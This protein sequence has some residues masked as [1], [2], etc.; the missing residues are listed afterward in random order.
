MTI[1]SGLRHIWPRILGKLWVVW[2]VRRWGGQGSLWPGAPAMQSPFAGRSWTIGNY[3]VGYIALRLAAGALARARGSAWAHQ[4]FH[5][6]F[7]A[8]A[9]KLV[10][11]EGF[12]RSPWL[13]QQFGHHHHHMGQLMTASPLDGMGATEG[14]VHEDQSGQTW[15]YMD[16]AWQALQG[17]DA[18]GQL[19]TA[20]PL[21]GFGQLVTASPLDGIGH[22]MPRDTP[23]P[24]AIQAAY[25]Q[26]GGVNPYATAY[27]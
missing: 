4:F 8:L 15:M 11:T 12:A 6:G 17:H 14:Q 5:G 1:A 25:Q 10:W 24:E 19:V 21:D 13:Q 23:R 2:A 16:G 7:D 26:A 9:T 27:M 3:I 18:Y 20:S 22:A